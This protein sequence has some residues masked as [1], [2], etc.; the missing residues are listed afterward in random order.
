MS[1]PIVVTTTVEG[2]SGLDHLVDAFAESDGSTKW[3]ALFNRETGKI[4]LVPYEEFD[5]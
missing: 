2:P 3:R 1:T 4:I 5:Q